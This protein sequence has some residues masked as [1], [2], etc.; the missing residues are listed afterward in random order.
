VSLQR[1]LGDLQESFHQEKY[2]DSDP[3]E[4]VHRYEDPWDQEAVALL[5]GLLA[6]GNVKQIRRSV[7]DALSRISRQAPSPRAFVEGLAEPEALRIAEAAFRGFT[8]RF[9]VGKDLVLLFALLARSWKRH[10]SLGAHFVSCLDPEASDFEAALNALITEWRS[11]A[12]EISPKTARGSFGY[13]LTSPEAGSCCKRWCMFLRWMGRKD[14]L[15]PGLWTEEGALVATFPSGRWLKSSQLVIPLDTHTGRISQYLALT[16]RKSL[17]WLAAQEVTRTLKT[18]DP[19]DP[20]RYDFAL[21]R[22]G[23]LDLCQRKYRK[24]ICEQCQLL[25]ACRFA[26]SHRPGHRK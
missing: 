9:N 4:F 13:L 25:P 3:L 11:W 19:L 6:Y 17:N 10:G 22:L 16:R 15:D 23:I 26:A 20:T 24:H 21:A 7:Q 12:R 8:H 18:C 2:L 5:A 14:R 1:L